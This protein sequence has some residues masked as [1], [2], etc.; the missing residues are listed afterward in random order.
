MP[1]PKRKV[2][3]LGIYHVIY[4]GIN[5]QDVFEDTEDSERFLDTLRKYEPICGFKILSYCLM[6]NHVHLIIKPG[7]IPLGRIFQRVIPSFVYWYNRKYERVGSLFQSPFKSTPINSENQLLTAVRYVHLN[8]VKAGICPKPQDYKFSSFKTY[9]SNDLID[10]SFV[11][12]I[13]S[14]NDFFNFNCTSNDDHCLDIDDEKPRLSDARA[15]K[16]MQDLSGCDNVTQFQALDTETRDTALREM[17]KA[18]ISI[19]RANRMTGISCGVIRKAIATSKY[20]Q[21]SVS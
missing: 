2:S 6:S 21:K 14:R 4:R 17:W 11:Q 7:E 8:P 9:Y 12:S 16:L 1:T 18:G 10:A 5:K 19:S 3:S 20:S 15:K 13:V